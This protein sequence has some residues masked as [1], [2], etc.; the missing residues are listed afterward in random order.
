MSS[1]R[2]F[3]IVNDVRFAYRTVPILKGVSLSVKRGEIA[4]VLGP[5]G[6]GKTTFL[7]CLD[8]LLK[9]SGAV[10]IDGQDVSRFDRRRIAHYF[11]FVPQERRTDFPYTGF[12]IVLMGRYAHTRFFARTGARDIET[13]MEI[14]ETTG[15]WNL[16]HRPFSE[17]SGGE[18]QK[19]MIARA[20]AQEPPVLLCDEPTLHLDMNSQMNILRILRQQSRQRQTTIF[21]VSHDLNLAHQFADRFILLSD[22]KVFAAGDRKILTEETIEAVFKIRPVIL[23][24]GNL[25]V[26][27]FPLV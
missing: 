9:P 13:V 4:A 7:K 23:R 21:F 14:M 1:E 19:I 16:A 25:T 10:L 22:G 2:F 11:G 20:L 6:T 3:V 24:N 18:K 12:E 26:F 5:N 15:T 27:H 8:H 17:L